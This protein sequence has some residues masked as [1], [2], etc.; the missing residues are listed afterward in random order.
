MAKRALEGLEPGE[1][2]SH[3]STIVDGILAQV[4]EESLV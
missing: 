3:L 2:R 4:P 1:W